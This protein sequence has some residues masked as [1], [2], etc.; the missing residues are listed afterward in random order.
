MLDDAL[1]Y[2]PQCVPQWSIVQKGNLGWYFWQIFRLGKD[3]EH[4]YYTPVA[5]LGNIMWS[6]HFYT[7][8]EI[9][10]GTSLADFQAG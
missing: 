7:K 10:A 3:I 4:Q 8:K 1:L 2:D 6:D 5:Q 9:L